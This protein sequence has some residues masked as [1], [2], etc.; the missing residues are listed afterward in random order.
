MRLKKLLKKSVKIIP[1]VSAILLILTGL[2]GCYRNVPVI[3]LLSPPML[4]REQIAIF[5]AL[6]SAEGSAL[7]LKFP[8]S[9]EF[10]SA[11]V[12]IPT[13]EHSDSNQVMVFY[14]KGGSSEPT[15][16]LTFLEKRET[17]W[18]VTHSRSFFATGIEQVEFAELGDSSRMNIIISTSISGQNGIN[19]HVIAFDEESGAP[20]E[21]YQRDFC[22]FR[23]IGDFDNSGSNMLLSINSGRNENAEEAFA[24]FSR[25]RAGEYTV[26]RSVPTDS[27]ARDYIAAISCT[28][29][30][31]PVV[32]IEYYTSASA[33]IAN[34]SLILWQQSED[35]PDVYPHS[36][37]FGQNNRLEKRINQFTALAYARDIDGSGTINP[38]RNRNFPGYTSAIPAHEIVRAA[39]WFEVMSDEEGE[40][41]LEPLYYTYLGGN[42]DYVFFFPDDWQNNVTVTVNHD[43]CS[44]FINEVV[45]WEYDSDRFR[46]IRDVTVPL[47]TIVTVS[48]DGEMC[49]E[50][51]GEEDI[52][53]FR[54]FSRR[55]AQY[56]YYV[57]IHNES[58][59]SAQLRRAL[60][61]I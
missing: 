20:D 23:Q 42:N 56:D 59:S 31:V 9:G 10:G 18:E 12:F 7:T 21:V 53:E 48:K 14:E 1:K 24:R 61:V 57:R 27:N 2:S 39:E 17:R 5:D 19:L 43:S 55:G 35:S 37:V 47:L 34:T 30:E 44:C 40:V 6:T 16:R 33:R 28:A 29:G 8:K 45:F 32:F 41:R 51:M 52:D 60:R 54:L 46:N 26:S 4:T 58:L 15:I 38:A 13:T 3:D 22:I 11:F 36:F 49:D 50:H 25:W